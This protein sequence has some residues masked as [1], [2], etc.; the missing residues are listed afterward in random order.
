LYNLG[1]II[2]FQADRKDHFLHF[3]IDSPDNMFEDEK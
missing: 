3:Y 1:D 2:I